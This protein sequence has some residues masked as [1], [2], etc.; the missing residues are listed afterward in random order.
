[1][2]KR[3]LSFLYVVFVL[4][5]CASAQGIIIPV[6]ANNGD[7]NPTTGIDGGK[8]T[9][10]LGGHNGRTSVRN[11][12]VCILFNE[13]YANVSIVITDEENVDVVSENNLSVMEGDAFKYNLT[14]FGSG[15]YVV[16]IRDDNGVLSSGV[17]KIE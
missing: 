9:V 7:N 2:V 14:A 6:P 16:T 10:P 1:M 4:C 3:L 8:T 17:V 12:S 15:C 13:A 11:W 5:V